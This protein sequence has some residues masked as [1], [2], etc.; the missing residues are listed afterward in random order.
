MIQLEHVSKVFP[1]ARGAVRALD[2]VSLE[3]RRGQFVAICGASGCGKSTLLSLVGGLAL[4]TSGRVIVDN[5]EL[6]RLSSAERARFRAEKL[7]FVFQM[8]HLLPYLTVLDNVLLAAP[9]ATR[10][11]ARGE[12]E[13]WLETF[14]LSERRWHRPGELSVGQRQRVAMARALLNR[15][16]LLLA[17]EPTGNLDPQTAAALLESLSQY[18]A[19]GGTILLVTHDAQ[20]AAH[21]DYRVSLDQG[22]VQAEPSAAAR[23]YLP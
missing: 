4:P 2:D 13:R 12:A 9:P 8:F 22:R 23:G 7:G 19:A 6:S 20:A 17:D 18:H 14:G 5:Q 1:T 10:R 3:V 15:P 16:Q 21:A 11:S